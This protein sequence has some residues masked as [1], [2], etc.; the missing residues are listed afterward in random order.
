MT[1][2]IN[3]HCA[4]ELP[5]ARLVKIACMGGTKLKSC[6]RQYHGC[7]ITEY[8]QQRRMSRGEQLLSET[9]LPIGQI[10]RSV[11]YRSASRF[12]ELFRESTGLTP[13]LSYPAGPAQ[14]P[15]VQAVPGA[16]GGHPGHPLRAV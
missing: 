14:V 15:A 6:F 4:P 3:D 1:A 5:Q 8:I 11:G 7:T 10:A 2:Y 13:D 9:D 16:Y 12:T